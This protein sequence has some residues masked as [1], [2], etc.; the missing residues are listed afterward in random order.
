MNLLVKSDARSEAPSLLGVEVRCANKVLKTYEGRK[1][2][3]V[4]GF[5]L[6]VIEGQGVIT[7]NTKCG[8]CK[9]MVRHDIDF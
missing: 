5:L 9:N 8:K 2:L 4:C 6:A 7:V 3:K 1:K